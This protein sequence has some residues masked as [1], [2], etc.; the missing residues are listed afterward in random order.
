MVVAVPRYTV[1]SLLLLSK[2]LPFTTIS[3]PPIEAVSVVLLGA[4]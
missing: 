3:T 2:P 1:K 4:I